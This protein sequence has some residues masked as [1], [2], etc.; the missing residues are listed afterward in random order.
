M[1][2]RWQ[3]V[4]DEQSQPRRGRW[5]TV[6]VSPGTAFLRGLGDSVS[7]GLGDEAR[8]ALAGAQ[9]FLGGGDYG[10]A[11][12]A[13]V[14]RSRANLEE[15]REQ[16]PGSTLAGEVAGYLV[17]GFG[18]GKAVARGASL[19][20][21]L[22]RSAAVGGAFSG[23]YGAASGVTPE[24]RL[25]GGLMG[26]GMGAA[27]G[28]G[29]HGI[30]GE[31][32][33]S[34]A[35]AGRRWLSG[36]SGL[37]A[38]PG[39]MGVAEMA[40]EDLMTTARQNI[41]LGVRSEGDLVA[42]MQSA[43]ARDPTLT[44]A[45]VL[46][47]SGQGRLA[48]LA[49]APGQTGQRVEDFFTERA[50][51]Q[52]DE[53]SATMLGR[54]PATGDALEQQ[55]REA[56]RTQG[57]ELYRPV[58]NQALTPQARQ[59][60]TAL[61]RSPLFQHRAVQ[62]AWGRAGA[63]ISDDVALG[64]V[65]PDAAN[66]IAHRLHYAKVALDEMLEDPTKLSP[67]IRNMNNASIAAA[68]DQLLRRME[69]I[70]PGYNAARAQMADLGSARRAIAEGRQAFTRQSFVTPEA[71]SRR[72]SSLTPGERPYF[73]AGVEDALGNM[74]ASAGRDGRRNVAATLLSDQTQ[75]RLRAIFGSEADS[76][77]ERL[78]EV[79]GR[80]EF[81]QRVRPSQ[82]S[83]TSNVIAQLSPGIAG[84]G[85]GAANAQ[86][87]PIA[88]ALMGGA[89]GFGI[90]AAGRRALQQTVGQRLE[91]AAQRQRDLLGRM[92][93][94]PVG[95]FQRAQGGLLSRAAREARRRES[96]TRLLR[97]Q[98]AYLSGIGAAGL[99]EPERGQ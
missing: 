66:S 88:G 75:S 22:A 11:Y 21:R 65:A 28:A 77:I 19:G 63:M 51:N 41:N 96:R 27:F 40:R 61:E 84:A 91:R 94:T 12:Q 55:V 13:Q 87:D 78:R 39:R 98:G 85:L 16:R 83:I 68:R 90:G 57:P 76:M 18:V 73:I 89:L 20:G 43:G 44:V 10:S 81:G 14:A 42:A 82:G 15:A 26:A 35:R 1:A 60:A 4:D 70:I 49:R 37:P 8:G 64:R 6:D 45:E 9:S 95:D 33:P 23:T 36:V 97:T 24:E 93:L 71:L 99:Y 2:G 29:A 17:P 46:G 31:A 74:I 30:L 69:H 72:M 58:L 92:Y 52:A 62:E 32:L 59:A 34:A 48:A 56:W 80:F 79:S 86:D 7:L 25:Q 38:N 3:V 47:Q 54:A 50:R 67:G 5:Q 53:V